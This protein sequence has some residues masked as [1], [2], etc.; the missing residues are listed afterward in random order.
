[1]ARPHRAPRRGRRGLV[2]V[3][4]RARGRAVRARPRRRRGLHRHLRGARHRAPRPE[5]PGPARRG[6]GPAR[7]GRRGRGCRDRRGRRARRLRR[8]RRIRLALRGPPRRARDGVHRGPGGARPARRGE[9]RGARR[10]GAGPRRGRRRVLR[11]L[12][13][14]SGWMGRGPRGEAGRR[15]RARAAR[16]AVRVGRRGAGHLRLLGADAV[17]LRRRGRHDTA[18]G[19]RPVQLHTRRSGR[20]RDAPARRPAV[21][22]GQPRRMAVGLPRRHVP[23]RRQDGP[24]PP[25]RRRGE[26]QRHLVRELRRGAPRGRRDRDRRRW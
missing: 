15:V 2:R 12:L 10:A 25:H 21:L 24:G 18:R 5:R 4:R 17:G 19:R 9:R 8:R 7:P 13:I 20:H 14:R 3:H 26:D 6:V 16:Q 23:R 22:V 11:R 1:M